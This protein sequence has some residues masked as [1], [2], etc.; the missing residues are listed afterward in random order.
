MT[1][2]INTTSTELAS[3][4]NMAFRCVALLLLAVVLSP[5]IHV[6]A[7]AASNQKLLMRL[8]AASAA[9]AAALTAGSHIGD[10]TGGLGSGPAPLKYDAPDDC[11]FH[12]HANQDVRLACLLRTVNSEYDTTNFS[13]IPAEHTV[14]LA[15]QCNDTISARSSLE[16]G[17]FA[18]LTRL[19]ELSMEYCKLARLQPEA[20]HGLA[21]LRNLTVRTHNVNWPALS[22]EIETDAFVNT[23]RLER[24]DLS[25]NNIWSLP[26]SLFCALS[27]LRALN[28]SANRLQDVTD[29]GF[30]EKVRGQAAEESNGTATTMHAPTTT[31]APT[32]PAAAADAAKTSCV[33]DVELLDVSHNHFVLLPA[34]GFGIL[35]RL[36]QLT[37]RANEISMVDDKALRGLK[38]LQILD[39]SSNKI[40]ALPSELFADPAS[41]IQEIYLQNNSISVL[42]PKLFANLEQ[43]QALDLASNKIT[44]TWI[45]RSTFAGLIRL[46]L[47]NLSNNHI[48]KLEPDFFADL[49]TLQILNLRF[50]QLETIAAD[51]FAPMNNLHTLL[52]S[53]NNLKYL[54]AYSLNGLYVL[55]LLSLDNNQLN[56]VHPEA[57][58]NCSSLQDLNL[59]GNLLKTVPLALKDMRLLRTVD[60]GE[61]QIVALGEQSFRGMTNLY[62]LRLIGNQLENV[63]KTVFRDLPSLQILNLAHNRIRHVEPGTFEAT[64]SIQAIRLDGNQLLGT[65]D[66]F[67][68]I[69]SLLWLNVSDNLL[70]SFDYAEIPAGLLWLDVHKN[71]ITNLTDQFGV[72]AQLRLQTLDASFN[73]IREIGPTSVP[74]SIELLFLNDNLIY[75]VDAH[76][77]QKK[78]NLTRVDLYANQI[79][80]MDVKALRL[81]PVPDHRALPEFYIGGNPFVCDCNIEWLQKINQVGSMF[82]CVYVFTHFERVRVCIFGR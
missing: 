2:T 72:N 43:L 3:S 16:A 81:A 52:L 71:A 29:L 53:H 13:V 41:T 68:R 36:R 4:S 40:V 7:V 50:N 18:H 75:A 1:A 12:I 59:N 15:I 61:N 73:H 58:R 80:S 14:S 63:T 32:T 65:D 57:F 77:F 6:A 34:N 56:G 55:S 62:G 25:M 54:D 35:K 74:H 20:L 31:A 79:S 46:V 23:R 39:L 9:S 44:S 22:L 19:G 17:S 67:A 27:S 24:L 5:Q 33:L 8:S 38:N 30:R 47:L 82:V 69:P 76:T 78:A 42:S 66:L 28:M 21:D 37:V 26:E 48:M 60:L 11:R 45:D 64:S 10:E 49:Y 51:T 70:S